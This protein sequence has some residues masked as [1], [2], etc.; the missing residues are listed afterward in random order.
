[1]T[2]KTYS[3]DEAY[4]ATLE[5]FGGDQ[6][7]AKVWTTKYALKDA[8]GNLYEKSPLD[9]HHRIAREIARI[10]AQYPNGLTESQVVELLD[11]FQYLVPQGSP[12]T[13]IG[14]DLQRK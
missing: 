12:M 1:M 11:H 7:A 2:Q 8:D 5:Y 10:E 3:Y 13:G 6:L 4:E 9:M 14:N